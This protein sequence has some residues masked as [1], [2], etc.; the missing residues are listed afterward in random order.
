MH[1]KNGVE[2]FSLV[3]NDKQEGFIIAFRQQGHLKFQHFPRFRPPALNQRGLLW[4]DRFTLH[5]GLSWKFTGWWVPSQQSFTDTL[6]P[7]LPRSFPWPLSSASCRDYCVWEI[8]T[9]LEGNCLLV[10][11]LLPSPVC[12]S[13]RPVYDLVAFIFP[14]P[15][16]NL[17]S[18]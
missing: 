17:L 10:L 14:A 2:F 8:L 1:M 15:E 4:A 13:P 9:M 12:K 3:S 11:C 5:C 7:P 16:H 18:E 6:M